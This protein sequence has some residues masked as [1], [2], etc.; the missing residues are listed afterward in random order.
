VYEGSW[1]ANQKSGFGQC[2]NENGTLIHEGIFTNDFPENDYPNRLMS[3]LFTW[4]KV[5]E[6]SFTMGCT[7]ARD[8]TDK[9]RPEH[10]V[11][12]SEFYISDKE[13]TVAQYR[14]FCESTGRSMPPKPSWNWEDDNPMVNVTWNDAVAF[15]QWNNCRL[16]TEAEWEYAAQ[17]T[18]EPRQKRY[19]GSDDLRE[20]AYFQDNTT[21]TR[22][23]GKKKPNEL[24]IYEMSGNVSEWVQDWF[25]N[26][27][28]NAQQN[29]KGPS[30]GSHKIVRGGN[31]RSDETECR[32]TFRGRCEPNLS[33]DYIGFRV[34]RNW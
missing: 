34:V 12:L 1:V 13:V 2:F 25:G 10:S 33:T 5:P 32:I 4:V 31:W 3:V 16:P 8:C 24:L 18:K 9:D 30:Y 7:S 17:G 22:V 20:V 29:P 14:T 23:V 6:G 11:S 27:S 21:R 26:Y 28:Q 19:S 15:C